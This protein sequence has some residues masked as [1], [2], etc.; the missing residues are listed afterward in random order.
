MCVG[1]KEHRDAVSDV[2]SR[3][4]AAFCRELA[5]AYR[6]VQQPPSSSSYG[7]SSQQQ[8]QQR[9]NGPAASSGNGYAP[10]HQHQHQ[11]QQRGVLSPC[12]STGSLGSEHRLGPVIAAAVAAAGANHH[13][14]HGGA[15]VRAAH[16]AGALSGGLAA[17]LLAVGNGALS[18]TPTAAGGGGGGGGGA[19]ELG[20][21]RQS[22][23]DAPGLLELH[24]QQGGAQQGKGAGLPPTPRNGARL[25]NGVAL[26]T[27]AAAGGGGGTQVRSG[28][29]GSRPLPAGMRCWACSGRS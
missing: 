23:D 26:G 25:A 8:Q 3:V 5:L 9:A 1:T 4:T 28:M 11:Q 7:A 6:M 17:G 12:L 29:R 13:Q 14:H 22:C 19:S 2:M 24:G 10:L 16:S 18:G 15:G 20:S 27:V 21:R